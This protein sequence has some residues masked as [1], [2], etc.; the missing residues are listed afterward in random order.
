MG[1][2]V[3]M[4]FCVVVTLINGVCVSLKLPNDSVDSVNQ[5]VAVDVECSSRRQKCEMPLSL[6]LIV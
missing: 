4:H 5:N 6:F 1:R 2:A 3:F